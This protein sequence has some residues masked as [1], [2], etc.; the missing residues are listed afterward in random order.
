[1]V[2]PAV[3]CR[4]DPTDRFERAPCFLAS[5]QHNSITDRGGAL[6]KPW[7]GHDNQNVSPGSPAVPS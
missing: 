7:S 3:R 6:D 4:S 1:M 2:M 5:R